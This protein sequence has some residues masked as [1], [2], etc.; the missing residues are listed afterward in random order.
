MNYVNQLSE[1]S[2]I[3]HKSI[4]DCV[5]NAK[6]KIIQC[7]N[8]LIAA[9]IKARLFK[10]TL[11]QDRHPFEHKQDLTDSLGRRQATPGPSE[12]FVAAGFE[13]AV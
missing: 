4:L 1:T 3:K 6:G 10:F 5:S 7:P 2:W 9:M 12:L 13:A 11:L 8:L